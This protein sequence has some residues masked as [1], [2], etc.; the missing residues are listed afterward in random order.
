MKTN[1]LSN[2]QI[3]HTL[4]QTQT[5][6]SNNNRANRYNNVRS[7]GPKT[8]SR[9]RS[10]YLGH[11]NNMDNGVTINSPRSEFSEGF[12]TMHEGSSKLKF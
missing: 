4:N 1:N 10:K 11:S 12:N 8:G 9:G 5:S 6:H 7:N 2:D 3:D